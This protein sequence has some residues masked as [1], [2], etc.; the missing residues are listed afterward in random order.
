MLTCSTTDP[1]LSR[2]TSK[3]HADWYVGKQDR[4]ISKI[5]PVFADLCQFP[6]MLIQVGEHEILRSDAERLSENARLVGVDI[7]LEIWEGMWHVW[8]LSAGYMPESQ[9]AIERIGAFVDDKM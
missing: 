8:H 4:R 3:L 5:S 2:E 1:L 9:Q 7:T 6:P